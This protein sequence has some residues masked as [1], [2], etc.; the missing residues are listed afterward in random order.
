MA[1]EQIAVSRDDKGRARR[2]L[3]EVGLENACYSLAIAHPGALT[4]HNHPQFRPLL[5]SGVP[6]DLGAAD[7]LRCRE[8]GVPRY[9]EFRRSLRMAP[10]SSFR[11]LADGDATAAREIEKVYENVE[12]VDLIVGVMADRKPAG[13]AISDTAFR[14]FLLMAARRL[15][16]D[17]FFTTDY[18][19]AVYTREGLD[20]IDDATMAG[21][22]RRRLPALEPALRGVENPFQPWPRVG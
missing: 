8:T 6:L 22:L 4:L 13:F 3:E 12:D 19:E 1:F 20:W 9:N 18:R 15:R 5:P 16:S 2:R 14:I 10:A 21:I 7:I 11:S 17:P